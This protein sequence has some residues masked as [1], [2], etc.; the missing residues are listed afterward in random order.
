VGVVVLL[1]LLEEELPEVGLDVLR[2]QEYLA[3]VLLLVVVLLLH[4]PF[5]LLLLLLPLPL[6]CYI[7]THRSLHGRRTLPYEVQLATTVF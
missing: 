3:R 4:R 2:P 6:S 1:L 7:H 5:L